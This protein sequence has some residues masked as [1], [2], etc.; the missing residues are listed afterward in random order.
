[1]AISV[2]GRPYAI[3]VDFQPCPP[4]ADES[5][6]RDE[7]DVNDLAGGSVFITGLSLN[8]SWGRWS[9]GDDLRINVILPKSIRGG[10]LAVELV[11]PHVL[12]HNQRLRVSVNDGPPQELVLSGPG[13]VRLDLDKEDAAGESLSLN[14]GL[15][16]ASR[17]GKGETR[18]LG[19]G[20]KAIRFMRTT[21]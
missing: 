11:V 4:D 9:D 10:V 21:Q 18:K 5:S 14:I 8:E 2:V 12:H 20:L 13:V 6:W 16:D 15:P 19:I 1:M 17:P 3:R 7:V